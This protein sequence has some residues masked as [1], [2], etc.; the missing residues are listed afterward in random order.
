MAD[1]CH[2]CG[3]EIGVRD[4]IMGVLSAQTPGYKSDR[5]LWSELSGAQ[6]ILLF[7]PNCMEKMWLQKT[8]EMLP[9]T[10]SH[11]VPKPHEKQPN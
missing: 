3:G 11:D 6:I 2:E 10:H 7:H 5:L 4:K 8:E 9:E 1:T